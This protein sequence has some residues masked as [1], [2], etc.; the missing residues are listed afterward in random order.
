MKCAICTSADHRVV[1]TAEVDNAIR[2]RR[3]CET[4]GHRWTTFETVERSDPPAV[5]VAAPDPFG[6]RTL[7]WLR[8]SMRQF[9]HTPDHIVANLRPV[10]GIFPAGCGVYFLARDRTILY[11]GISRN[12][13]QRLVQHRKAAEIPFDSAWSFG[14]PADHL[15][16]IEGF[17]LLWLEPAY[18]FKIEPEHYALA[19]LADEARAGRLTG[20]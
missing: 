12:V 4:C 2:R 13:R 10:P 17:Y 11:V 6:P 19:D 14:A 15:V 5:A 16:K 18:N 8:R 3:K 1:D 7:H 20:S 9:I